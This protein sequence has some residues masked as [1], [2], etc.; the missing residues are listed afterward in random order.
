VNF[1]R[2]LTLIPAV[3]AVAATAIFASTS[4]S[5]AKAE[6]LHLRCKAETETSQMDARY[7]ERTNPRKTRTRFRTHFEGVAENGLVVGA[8]MTVLVDS[9][10]VG[11]ITLK[12]EVPGE[13]EGQLRFDSKARIGKRN[14]QPFPAGFPLV[15]EGSM[16]EVTF[17]GATVLGCEL[18]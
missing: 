17:N 18:I 15:N 6:K 11:T 16:V 1:L 10:A 13:V 9:V 7:E 12:E 5:N 4:A 8:Q 3:A 2:G 14:V